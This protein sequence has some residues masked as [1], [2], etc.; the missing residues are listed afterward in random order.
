MCKNTGFL[1][2]IPEESDGLVSSGIAHYTQ[3]PEDK[4]K[5]LLDLLEEKHLISFVIDQEIG[6]Q[7][8]ISKKG[9]K[10]LFENAEL[11]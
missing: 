3:L 11:K 10:Y 9:R 2:K 7:Y 4:I 8:Y 1:N 6:T 5:Y